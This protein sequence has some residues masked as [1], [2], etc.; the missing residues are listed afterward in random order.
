LEAAEEIGIELP[1][2]CRSGVCGQC[3]TKLLKGRVVMETEEALTTA[4]K[5]NGYILACQ[6]H[7]RS[8]VTLDA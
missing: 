8:D 3:K 4:E 2:E 5:S 1:F 7:P 6:A